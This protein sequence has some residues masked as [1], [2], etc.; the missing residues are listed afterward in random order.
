MLIQAMF[1]CHIH[2]SG[3]IRLTQAK[4]KLSEEIV[5]YIFSIRNLTEIHTSVADERESIT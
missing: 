4:V 3:Y 5:I 1:K 2:T